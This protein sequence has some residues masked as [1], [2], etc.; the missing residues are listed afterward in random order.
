VASRVIVFYK[1]IYCLVDEIVKNVSRGG[2]ALQ[3]GPG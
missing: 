1:A 3:T 2:L